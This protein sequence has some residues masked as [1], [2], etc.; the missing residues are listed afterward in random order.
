M[1]T[2][3]STPGSILVCS[4]ETSAVRAK[5]EQATPQQ[6]SRQQDDG[7]QVI[8]EAS[9]SFNALPGKATSPQGS[10]AKTMKAVHSSTQA[11]NMVRHLPNGGDL[12]DHICR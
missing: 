3:T 9:D 6:L 2:S 7:R 1:V 12:L 8:F 4:T 10:I 5:K 11:G